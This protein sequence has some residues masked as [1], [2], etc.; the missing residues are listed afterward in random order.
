MRGGSQLQKDPQ[1]TPT[2]RLT[3]ERQGESDTPV[4]KIERRSKDK[5]QR[6]KTRRFRLRQLSDPRP[7]PT[8][9]KTGPQYQ[10]RQGDTKGSTN[11]N[12]STKV[13]RN[14]MENTRK[15][16]DWQTP[17]I[18]NYMCGFNKIVDT[19]NTW[20]SYSRDTKSIMKEK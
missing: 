7:I 11:G 6:A 1:T 19:V 9:N 10:E 8:D 14:R 15:T 4:R 2:K 16:R 18:C 13:R 3:A 12:S 5:R 20:P 17:R